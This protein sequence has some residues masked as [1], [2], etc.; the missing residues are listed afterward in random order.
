MPRPTPGP[1]RALRVL[2]DERL[3]HHVQAGGLVFPTR[4]WVLLIGPGNRPL[5]FP[6]TVSLQ[7]TDVRIETE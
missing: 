3:R 1:A 4:R 6:A 5:P 2:T 7:L